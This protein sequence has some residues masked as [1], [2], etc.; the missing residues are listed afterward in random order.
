MFVMTIQ[1]NGEPVRVE[2]GTTI[3]G[4]LQLRKLLPKNVAVE[5]NRRLVRAE[6]YQT[7]LE[8]GDR[9]EIVSFV[10]GG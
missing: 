7:L 9:I 8:E 2:A 4:L 10:G 1:I 5:R 3:A 6:Q